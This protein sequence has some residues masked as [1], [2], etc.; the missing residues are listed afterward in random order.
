MAIFPN[1]F[2]TAGMGLPPISMVRRAVVAAKPRGPYITGGR[3]GNVRF[4]LEL[5]KAKAAAAPMRARPVARGRRRRVL[6]PP[7][8]VGSPFSPGMMGL[9]DAADPLMP[10]AGYTWTDSAGVVH[11]PADDVSNPDPQ[12]LVGQVKP[13]SKGWLVLDQ[14]GKLPMWAKI[15]GGIALAAGAA[16]LLHIG[17]R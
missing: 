7:P 16:A 5:A 1:M 4:A 13:T 8:R 10:P 15:G 9:G 12:K 6:G 14:A 17:R 3:V 11:F 2:A